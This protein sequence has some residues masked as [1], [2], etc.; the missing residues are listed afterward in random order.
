VVAGIV[1]AAADAR[2]WAPPG[3]TVAA[4]LVFIDP[5][6]EIIPAAAPRLFVRLAQALATKPAALVLFEM[7]GGTVL[8]PPGWTCIKRL[9]KGAHQPTVGVFLRR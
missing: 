9:G 7:P 8:S 3:G 4:D 2:T 5:P 6:Y 1:V